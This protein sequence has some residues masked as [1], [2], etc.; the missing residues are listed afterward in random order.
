MSMCMCVKIKGQLLEISAPSTVGRKDQAHIAR[1]LYPQNHPAPPC[2]HSLV[3]FL[4]KQ[5]KNKNFFPI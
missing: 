2:V 1:A 4:K 3:H 5:N